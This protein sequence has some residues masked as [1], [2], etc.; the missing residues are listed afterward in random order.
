MCGRYTLIRLADFTD[1]FPW[2]RTA[3]PSEWT[4]PRY[5]IAP[6]QRVAIVPNDGR[7]EVDFFQ[8]GLVPS[9]A[10]DASCGSRMINARREG[11]AEKPAFR[12]AFRRRRCLVPASGFYEWKKHADGKTK[13]PMHIRM[14]DG[15]PFAFAGLWEVWRGPEGKKL[16][17]CTIITGPPNDLVRDI[18]DRMPSILRPEHYHKWLDPDEASPEALTELLQP[19]PAE[20]M[21]A[22]PVGRAVNSPKN[23]S[24]ELI[25]PAKPEA[26]P[27]AGA[28]PGARPDAGQ[29]RRK[30]GAAA[31]D[32]QSLF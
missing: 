32:Q 27:A 13:T 19:F 16:S 10:R 9:W 7:N 25:E 18:H 6:T 8:W 26:A 5:N 20:W 23:E 15:K 3:P 21:E 14:R 31:D 22:Y 11:I 17:T 4:Q 12:S 2:I 29:R 1:M 24:P 30:R 28:L